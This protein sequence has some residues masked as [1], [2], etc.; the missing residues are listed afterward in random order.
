VTIVVTARYGYSLIDIGDA[1][2]FAADEVIA[3]V[4]GD[5]RPRVTVTDMHVHVNDITR[6]DPKRGEL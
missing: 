6:G 4:L 1:I 5:A 2:R 3:E